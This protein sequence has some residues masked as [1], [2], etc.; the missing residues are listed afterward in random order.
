MVHSCLNVALYVVVA[1]EIV[2]LFLVGWSYG[3][4][5]VCAILLCA[6]LATRYHEVVS[7]DLLFAG[8]A[9]R[10]YA[11]RKQDEMHA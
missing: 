6:A 7:L 11:H 10:R 9:K 8:F 3:D 5:L 4:W 2:L 1:S